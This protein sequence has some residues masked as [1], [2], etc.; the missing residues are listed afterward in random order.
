VTPTTVDYG[1]HL[2]QL[3]RRVAWI[4]VGAMLFLVGVAAVGVILLN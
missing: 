3:N 1:S 4:L 2:R